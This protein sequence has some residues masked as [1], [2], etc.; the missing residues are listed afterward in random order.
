MAM[1]E[2]TGDFYIDIRSLTQKQELRDSIYSI[3]G[4]RING[5]NAGKLPKGVYIVNNKK[6]I[7]K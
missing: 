3:S 5:N 7:V 1:R 4:M 2:K 6:M